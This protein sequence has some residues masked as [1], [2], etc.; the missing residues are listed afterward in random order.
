MNQLGIIDIHTH[1]PCYG[2]EDRMSPAGSARRI[3]AEMDLFGV[4]I[5]GL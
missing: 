3:L 4:A 5:S 1:Q 2:I